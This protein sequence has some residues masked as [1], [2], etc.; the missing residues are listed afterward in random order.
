MGERAGRNVRRFSAPL[1]GAGA[2]SRR[3]VLR[4]AAALLA[5]L[6]TPLPAASAAPQQRQDRPPLLVLAAAS[7]KNALDEIGAR[8]ATEAGGARVAASY[9]GS[10]VLARQM[11]NGAPVDLFVSADREWMDHAQARKLIRPETRIDLLG[12]ALVL[13]GPKGAAPVAVESGFD[14]AGLLG[15]GDRL[16]MGEPRSVPAG[17]YA[18]QALTA[19]GAW[20]KVKG[21]AAFAE[22]VR[23]ALALV[24]RGEAPYGIVYR[25][26]AAADPGVAVV[27]AFPEDSHSP[28]VYSAAVAA[29]TGRA[30]ESAALLAWLRSPSARASFEKQGFTVLGE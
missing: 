29:S 5:T 7:L 13:V 21:R 3:G 6:A 27:G 24:S 4:R 2:L 9:A 30:A 12:N 14:L 26:D 18:E 28:I 25:S 19:L 20:D 1:R 8:Y 11:E 22:N 16:A 17:R 23:A 10:G 15:P